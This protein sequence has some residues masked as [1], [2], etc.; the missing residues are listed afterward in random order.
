[1]RETFAAS[2]ITHHLALM[3]WLR[4]AKHRLEILDH[5]AA[6]DIDASQAAVAARRTVV[7]LVPAASFCTGFGVSSR[8]STK[9]VPTLF[10]VTGRDKAGVLTRVVKHLSGSTRSPSPRLRTLHSWHRFSAPKGES[11]LQS[12]RGEAAWWWLPVGDAGV[13]FVGT[14]LVGDLIRYR[15]GDPAAV[16]LEVERE[17]W[18]Y[19]GERPNYLFEGQR[20]GEPPEARHADEWAWFLAHALAERTGVGLQ[21]VLPGGAPG[22][23]VITGDDDQAALDCYREQLAL[24]GDTPV[25]YFL[26]PLTKHTP[27]TLHALLSRPGI[28]L[29]LH[30][31]ALE[32]PDKYDEKFREQAAWFRSIADRPPRS[33]RNHGFLNRGYWGHLDVWIAG[34]VEIS[35]NIPGLDGTVL[36]GSLLPARMGCDGV[37]TPHWSIL[38]VLGDG[39]L[40]VDKWSDRVVR[41]RVATLGRRVLERGIPGVLVFNL[42][43]ENVKR[44]HALHEA[45][46]KLIDQGF[47]AWGLEQCLDWFKQRDGTSA[48]VQVP[49]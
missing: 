37:L 24:I 12:A 23:V 4:D 48:I 6:A 1:M 14:D 9:N 20:L 17:R 31:D 2:V 7:A 40:F 11:V 45:V 27:D 39:V 34:G 35:S 15:Q 28:E 19:A 10:S 22:A 47:L 36:N 8:E 41:E 3:G 30:P 21:P 13:L 5:P 18:G 46:L 49:M 25:T 42:H 29:G 33:V 26:H 38:T 43:P 44:A 32:A 16:S